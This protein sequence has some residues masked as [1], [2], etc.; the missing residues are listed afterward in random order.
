MKPL[1]VIVSMFLVL[2][3]STSFVNKGD[4]DDDN[5]KGKGNDKD[6]NQ[7]Y[8]QVNT[9]QGLNFICS[10]PAQL[11]NPQTI[12]N[13]LTLTFKSKKKQCS[14]HV[15]VSSY[16]IP[17]GADRNNVPLELLWT[18]DNSPN[19]YNVVKTM[20]LSRHDQQLFVQPARSQTYHFR[21]DLRLKALGYDY[22]SG[23][24]NYTLM[25]TMTQP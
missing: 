10:T 14:M 3:S 12:N 16:N 13:A 20:Q 18:S 8:L 15:K 5:G 6:N 2:F 17:R 23:H 4:D 21:Y 22:P 7:H 25:F 19:A 11:E 9:H 24:Y 1:L